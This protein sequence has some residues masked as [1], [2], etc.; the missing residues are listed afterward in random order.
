MNT[1]AFAIAILSAALSSAAW[2]EDNCAFAPE[3]ERNCARFVGCVNDGETFFKGTSR[4]WEVGHVYGL[5]QTGEVCEGDWKF[6][7]S[8][9]KGEGSFKCGEDETF[10]MNFFNRG[11]FGL[12]VTGVAITSKGNRVRLWGSHDLPTFFA[13][14]YPDAPVP[15]QMFKCGD[16]WIPVPTEYPEVP[17]AKATE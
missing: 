10:E 13:E 6:I 14:R 4:G 17:E 8:I 15:G 16:A 2:A 3:D 7:T 11:E 5:T 12:G 1:K 9:N